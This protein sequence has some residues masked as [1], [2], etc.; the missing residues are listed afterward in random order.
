ME[1][2]Y[3]LHHFKNFDIF[4]VGWRHNSRAVFCLS[5]SYLIQVNVH[6]FRFSLLRE[7]S[8]L[9]ATSKK[10]NS[11]SVIYDQWKQIKSDSAQFSLINIHEVMT[12]KFALVS[13]KRSLFSTKLKKTK[14]PYVQSLKIVF[15]CGF[16]KMNCLL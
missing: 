11:I 4:D 13:R 15:S 3:I 8:H 6:I 16:S 10:Y 5:L 1:P 2:Q 7:I 12:S 9:H 14:L